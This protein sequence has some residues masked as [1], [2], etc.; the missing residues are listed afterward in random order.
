MKLLSIDAK[1]ACRSDVAADVADA[2]EFGS[3][4]GNCSGDKLSVTGPFPS[5]LS[6]VARNGKGA[7]GE[8]KKLRHGDRRRDFFKWATCVSV[9]MA[10]NTCNVPI[11]FVVHGA[12]IVDQPSIE[13]TGSC[14]KCETE[15]VF[16]G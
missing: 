13:T 2:A 5:E 1:L 3:T 4:L 9:P 15:M 11:G 16:S 12:I 10:N 8:R 6:S 14:E 7:G